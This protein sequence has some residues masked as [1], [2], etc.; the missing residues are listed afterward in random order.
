MFLFCVT[1][2]LQLLTINISCF[3]LFR[4]KASADSNHALAAFVRNAVKFW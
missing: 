4:Q 2:I 1:L 3:C